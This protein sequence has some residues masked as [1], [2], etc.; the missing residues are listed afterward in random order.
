MRNFCISFYEIIDLGFQYDPQ[1]FWNISLNK[2]YSLKCL[3]LG[4][5]RVQDLDVSRIELLFSG[6][7]QTE[8]GPRSVH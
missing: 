8:N 6:R 5:N 3:C 1:N 7:W 4:R 2:L